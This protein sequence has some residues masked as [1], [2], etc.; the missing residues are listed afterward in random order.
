M[1]ARGF[2]LGGTTAVGMLFGLPLD[3][4]HI[5]FSSAFVGYAAAAH[6]F[7]LTG[8]AIAWAAAGVAGIGFMNLTVSFALALRLALSAR[9]ASLGNPMGL[10]R[11]VLRRLR[12]SPREFLLP[13]RALEEPRGG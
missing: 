9:Q 10:V 3:I 5:A 7:T 13:P 4:R 1:Q 8:Q 11:A 2:L 12:S 6:D